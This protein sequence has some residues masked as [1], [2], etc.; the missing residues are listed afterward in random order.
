M[1]EILIRGIVKSHPALK[2][3]LK[4]AGNKKTPYQYVYQTLFMTMIS[5]G[6]M[7]VLAYLFFQENV[8]MLIIVLLFILTIGTLII[9]EFWLSFVDVQ[10]Q[11]AGREIDGDLL[12]VSEY[13]LVSLESGLPLGNSIQNISKLK[14]PGGVFFKK[15]FTEF[16]T[17]KD[18]ESAL[19]DGALYSP[20]ESLKIL[21]KRLKD[22]LVIGVDLKSVLE[23]FI[24]ESS[25]KK[26]VEISGYSKKLNPIIMLYL[27]LGIVVPS[28]GITFFIL[29][30]VMLN[31]TPEFLK[32]LLIL[33]FLSMFAFQYFA[34]SIFKFN[35][36]TL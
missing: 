24:H 16:K 31:V 20:S 15:I 14:R 34:Y 36:A 25:K 30:A 19:D 10:I 1:I 4:R 32:F 7:L 23:N 8:L 11:K 6:A 2:L 9:Y 17:G 21:L 27:I 28:L 5:V 12:F 33:I 22:S 3:K 29:G 18:L 35:K 13:F 26:L